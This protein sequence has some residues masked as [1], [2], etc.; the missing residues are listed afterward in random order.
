VRLGASTSSEHKALPVQIAK[1]L[2]PI[3]VLESLVA[4]YR[5]FRRVLRCLT[6]DPAV[7]RPTVDGPCPVQF[8]SL[9]SFN[10]AVGTRQSFT[11]PFRLDSFF[12]VR[13]HFSHRLRVSKRLLLY[14]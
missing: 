14:E 12:R 11:T 8:R 1:S 4:K 2:Y 13:R 9:C 6:I 5:G 3:S 10:P 7:A